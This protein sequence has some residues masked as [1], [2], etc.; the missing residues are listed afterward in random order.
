MKRNY[1]YYIISLFGLSFVTTACEEQKPDFFDEGANSVY[2]DY[3]TADEFQQS[4]RFQDKGEGFPEYIPVSIKLKL[5]GYLKENVRPV[6]LKMKP[7]EGYPEITAELPE[8]SFSNNEYEK[9]IIV[10][11]ACPEEYDI[12]YAISLYIDGSEPGSLSCDV[13]GCDEYAIYVKKLSSYEQ[14]PHWTDDAVSIT[15]YLGTWTPAKHEFFVK[16][17]GDESFADL[18][19]LNNWFDRTILRYNEM[20]VAELRRQ[21]AETGEP[22]KIEIP[23]NRECNYEKPAYWTDVHDRFFEYSSAVFADMA[24]S[25]GANTTNEEE[26]LGNT[27]TLEDIHKACVKHMM[28][29][30][31]RYFTEWGVSI[32]DFAY[33]CWFPMYDDV[34]YELVQPLCWSTE[35]EGGGEKPTKYYGEYSD[36]KYR[37]MIN[38]WLKHQ[39]EAGKQFMLWQMFPIIKNWITMGADWDSL[40][41]GE[42]AIKECYKVFKAAYDAA[43]EGTYSFSFPQLDI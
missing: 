16:L 24:N 7:V 19:K 39:K 22:V 21:Y 43:P 38:T 28:E 33:N 32:N 36:E 11:V 6:Y 4:V 34:E 20:A 31:N 2:F 41:G 3:K 12:E 15:M 37:F 17:T 25:V 27:A 14:P 1:L 42:K 29:E 35:G 10:N 18:W 9:E 30:Y 40:G 23:F 26:L 8:V 5:L 13:E